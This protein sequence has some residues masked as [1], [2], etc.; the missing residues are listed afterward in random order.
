MKGLPKLR[1]VLYVRASEDGGASGTSVESQE[2]EGREFCE[3]FE[4]EI[5]AVLV[6]NDFSAS[7]YAKEDR[8]N[9]EKLLAML[10]AGEINFVWTFNNA[11]MQRSLDDYTALRRLLSETGGYWGYGNRVYAMSDP[12]DRKATARDATESEAFVDDLSQ[13]SSAG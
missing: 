8:P 7:W 4:V 3:A 5:V 11:R 9:Y 6:D 1:G 12:A 2:F 10:A 13:T